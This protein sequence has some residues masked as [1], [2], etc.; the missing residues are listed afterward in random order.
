[1]DARVRDTSDVHALYILDWC[2]EKLIRQLT[3]SRVPVKDSI[4]R[5]TEDGTRSSGGMMEE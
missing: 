5:L 3:E 4:V 2:L 1:M